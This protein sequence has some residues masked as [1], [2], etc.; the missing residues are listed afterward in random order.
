MK[1]G[2]ISNLYPPFIRGGA[3]LIAALEAKGLKD[4]WQHVFVISSKPYRDFSSL[5]VSQIEEDGILVYRFFPLNIFYYLNDFKYPSFIR[6]LWHIF[7]I[8]NIFSY[9][10]IKNILLTEKPDVIITHN[11][12]GLGFLLPRLLKKLKIK[13]LHTLHDVQL[14]TPSGLILF[15]QENNLQHN[16][17]KIIG[18]AKL[19]R[20]LFASPEII[21]S[22]SKFLLNYYQKLGFFKKS[23][24]IF[25]PNP[26]KSIK[27]LK[28][29]NSYNLELLF[30]GQI[31]SAKGILELIKSFRDLPL[32]GSR[33]NII[34]VGP[35]LS[36]AK[37]LAGTD[38]RIRFF[39]WLAH[40]EMLPILSRMHVLVVPSLCY[41]NS[42]TVIYELLALG[43][44]VLAS[45]IGGVGEL[46]Q[47]GKNGWTYPAGD[48]KVLNQKILSIYQQ[49]EKLPHLAANCQNSVADYTLDK[50]IAKILALLNDDQENK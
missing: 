9:F 46:I 49:K 7:D 8:F 43:V 20:Y 44:P 25:L 21:V 45:D 50:Y 18:Y 4:S 5:N 23:K 6:M 15:K 12:M 17:F 37:K 13:H 39:G 48:F 30:L 33:L 3:E 29:H 34:G 35:D 27:T 1:I 2:I 47:E 19:M 28:K 32:P 42:P 31:H 36:V 11:L 22:P 10:K 38:P 14:A 40:H 26:I 16:F 24:K 41:E